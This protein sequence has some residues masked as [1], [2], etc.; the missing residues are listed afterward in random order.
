MESRT[1]M[2]LYSPVWTRIPSSGIL[3]QRT[4]G[5][6]N[7]DF[8]PLETFKNHENGILSEKGDKINLKYFELD[9]EYFE[10]NRVGNTR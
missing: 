3:T 8:F 9:L 1:C 4:C 7:L 6:Y 10:N 5:Y 2:L